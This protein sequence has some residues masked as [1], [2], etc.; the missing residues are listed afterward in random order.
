MKTARTAR[1]ARSDS[2]AGSRVAASTATDCEATTQTN[3][4]PSAETSEGCERG[5]KS[6]IHGTAYPRTNHAAVAT[7]SSA[8]AIPLRPAATAQTATTP[9]AATNVKYPKA[10]LGSRRSV[11]ICG[12]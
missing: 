2:K 3:H 1:G 4:V 10:R 11:S 6:A 9:V 5:P 7:T 8:R 12:R